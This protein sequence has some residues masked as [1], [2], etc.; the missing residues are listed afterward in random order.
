MK[1]L[2]ELNSQKETKKIKELYDNK[3]WGELE[4]YINNV[5]PEHMKQEEKNLFDKTEQEKN[6][7]EQEEIKEKTEGIINYIKKYK[8]EHGI[9]LTFREAAILEEAALPVSLSSVILCVLLF[10]SLIALVIVNFI[11]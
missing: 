9:D 5:I 1:K 6:I 2:E 3:K 7:K 4:N 8:E 11:Y 10:A